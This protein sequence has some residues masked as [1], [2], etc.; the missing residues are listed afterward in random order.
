MKT[1]QGAKS[2]DEEEENYN[3]IAEEKFAKENLSSGNR[4]EELV[5]QL[6]AIYLASNWL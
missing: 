1:L 3:D 4:G 2:V 5:F 6:A